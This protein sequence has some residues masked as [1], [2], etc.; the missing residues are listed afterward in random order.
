MWPFDVVKDYPAPDNA[1]CL[2]AVGQVFQINRFLLQGSPER[3]MNMLSMH[4]SRPSI[5]MR[6]P[7]A[8][9]VNKLRGC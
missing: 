9:S 5:E 7:A 6:M 3:L 1:M 8:V 4:R 2:V